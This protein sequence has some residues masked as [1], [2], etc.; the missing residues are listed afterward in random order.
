M[1][2]TDI[3][4][5]VVLEDDDSYDAKDFRRLMQATQI[6]PGAADFGSFLPGVISGLNMSIGVGTAYVRQ[7]GDGSLY[8]CTQEGSTLSHPC[9]ANG[10]GNPRIDQIILHLYDASA[11]GD[12]SAQY[13][14][15]IEDI[16]G[17]P[18]AG[19]TL[20]NRSGAPDLQTALSTSKAYILLAD[21]LM[22]AGASTVSGANIRD[23]RPFA[24][25]GTIPPLN[26]AATADA[27][28][29]IVVMQNGY[30]MRLRSGIIDGSTV[31]QNQSAALWW[32]PRR[33]P[34]THLRWFYQQ[35]GLSGDGSGAT[36][37]NWR[38][39]ICDASGR[40]VADTGSVALTGADGSAHVIKQSMS[41]P[42]SGFVFEPG[43]Y[44]VWMGVSTI[45]ASKGIYYK[46]VGAGGNFGNAPGDNPPTYNTF[47][48]AN[49]GGTTFPATG[50]I[51]GMTDVTASGMASVLLPNPQVALSI[52]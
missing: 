8:L 31:S 44:Y 19:A 2:Q 52:G 29:D 39:V 15:S 25:P 11:A 50:H 20:D 45:S 49:S 6:G 24:L 30:G 26:A 42:Y 4:G 13:R 36:T 48:W 47:L 28:K 51:K 1:A 16:Q 38:I 14:A 32:L 40:L 35:G 22:P 18:T 23:R 7:P 46:G 34:A 43:P 10:S 17:T 41:V 27:A 3:N 33:I 21:L 5:K 37:A 12:S 9:S